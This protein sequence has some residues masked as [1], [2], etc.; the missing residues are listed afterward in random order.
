MQ[1]RGFRRATE[2]LVK[3]SLRDEWSDVQ[4]EM[5]V[6]FFAPV[7]AALGLSP[8]D[9]VDRLGDAS[10]MPY[11]FMAE[12]F[13]TARFGDDDES[14]VVDDYLKRRGWR[15]TAPARR[16]LEALRDS[17]VSL[18]EVVDIDR[19]RS[20]GDLAGR[21]P[22]SLHDSRAVLEDAAG[23]LPEETGLSPGFSARD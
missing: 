13:F 1:T 22:T 11:A 4:V 18:Y 16:Y 2:S 23:T 20:M 9:I 10:D 14:N 21:P 15:E 8:D 3:W 19:G 17:T 7:S 6:G 12:E 5:C